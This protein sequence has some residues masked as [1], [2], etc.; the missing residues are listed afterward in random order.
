M[1]TGYIL[2]IGKLGVPSSGQ[3]QI[4]SEVLKS[5][6]KSSLITYLEGRASLEIVEGFKANEKLDKLTLQ[7]CFQC[8][9]KILSFHILFHSEEALDENKY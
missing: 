9:V 8:F 1:K 4:P 6:I 5:C 3:H 2:E 7:N